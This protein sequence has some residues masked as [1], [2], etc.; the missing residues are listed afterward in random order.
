MTPTRRRRANGS[1]EL[2]RIKRFRFSDMRND[3]DIQKPIQRDARWQLLTNGNMELS[4][5][6]FV[7]RPHNFCIT[8][9]VEQSPETRLLMQAVEVVI[10]EQ[11]R[12]GRLGIG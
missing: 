4:K 11:F 12:Q 1:S 8:N 9:F 2:S 10:K 5:T 3:L 6:S 7:A